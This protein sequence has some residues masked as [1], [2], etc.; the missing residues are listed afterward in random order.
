M[1]DVM[2][3]DLIRIE[4]IRILEQNMIKID[5]IEMQELL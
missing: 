4:Y 5:L 2:N 3:F 1:I